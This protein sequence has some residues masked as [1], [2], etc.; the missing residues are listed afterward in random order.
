LF[1][2]QS[3]RIIR[4][5]VNMLFQVVH[6]HTNETCPGRSPEQAKRLGEW[7]QS[8]KKT[9][10]VKVLSG[11]VSPMEH[12]FYITVETDDYP[13]LA[14]ALGALNTYGAGRTSPVLTLEQTLPMAE[15]GAFRAAK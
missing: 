1:N 14:R 8:L 9:S 13:T 3:F 15:A 6:T 10:G 11:Y 4:K 7:W 5:E 2:I 12:T